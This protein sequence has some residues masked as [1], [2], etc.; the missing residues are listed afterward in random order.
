V[1]TITDAKYLNSLE[2]GQASCAA[3]RSAV[4]TLRFTY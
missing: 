4:G 2:W 1:R 3:P